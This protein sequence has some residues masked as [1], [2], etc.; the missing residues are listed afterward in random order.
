MQKIA[1]ITG[2]STGIGNHLVVALAK[3]GFRVAFTY[4]SSSRAARELSDDLRK[5]GHDASAYQCDVGDEGEVTAFYASVVTD[6]GR[7]PDLLINNAGIQTWSPLLDL[8][9]S[10]W[11]NVI[12][13][14]LRGCF[15]NTQIAARLMIDGGITGT[16]INIGSGCNKLAF[17]NLVDYTSSK[18][19]IEQFTKVSAVELGPH[20]IR[21]NCIAP[22]AIETDRTQ[23]EASDYGNQW[24]E[25]TPLRRVG[26]PADL[27]G[28]ILFLSSDAA[29][30][31]TGQT[32]WVDG[33]VFSQAVWPRGN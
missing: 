31:V 8:K 1:V 27:V 17:A 23:D 29:A 12:R 32:I 30:F 26:T 33:G 18:G 11:D 13:T 10:D 14:N 4:R 2:G 5:Q 20:G 21:V 24:A 22:G 16:I 25:M 28:P 6:F 15:L 3:F 19:G 7:A 9:V